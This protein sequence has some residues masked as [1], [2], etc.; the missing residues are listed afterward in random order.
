MFD[1]FIKPFL[2]EIGMNKRDEKINKQKINRS[3][4]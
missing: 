2:D 1:S 3:I 4:K